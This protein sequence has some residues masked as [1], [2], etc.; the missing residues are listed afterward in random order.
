MPEPQAIYDAAKASPTLSN[1]YISIIRPLFSPL[2]TMGADVECLEVCVYCFRIFREAGGFIQH[3]GSHKK[4][5]GVRD[6]YLTQVCGRL[7][8][9][10]D[11]DLDRLEDSRQ[12]NEASSLVTKRALDVGE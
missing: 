10:A 1:T 5:D 9:R 8:A 11:A 7:R 3:V 6:S 12:P 2:I 4:E